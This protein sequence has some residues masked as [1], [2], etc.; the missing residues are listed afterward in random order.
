MYKGSSVCEIGVR[1]KIIINV[2]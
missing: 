2:N 1:L